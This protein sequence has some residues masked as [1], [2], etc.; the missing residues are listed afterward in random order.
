M[1]AAPPSKYPTNRISINILK[2]NYGVTGSVGGGVGS[3]F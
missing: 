1:G 3:G 2:V